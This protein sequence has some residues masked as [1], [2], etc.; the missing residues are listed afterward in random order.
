MVE[1]N[2]KSLEAKK[3]H[4][5]VWA[6]YTRRWAPD[7]K[8]V[9]YTT[10]KNNNIILNDSVKGIAVERDFYRVQPPTPDHVEVIKEWSSKSDV[11]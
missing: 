5:H 6:S 11:I 4:H 10:K 9:F 1:I 2:K 7:N 3:N 8:N